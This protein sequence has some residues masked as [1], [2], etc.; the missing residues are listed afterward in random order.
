MNGVKIVKGKV[1]I[2]R[3]AADEF[4]IVFLH[5]DKDELPFELS[6]PVGGTLHIP[7]EAKGGFSVGPVAMPLAEPGP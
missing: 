5:Q 3:L 2:T 1:T 4:L 7:I 6:W